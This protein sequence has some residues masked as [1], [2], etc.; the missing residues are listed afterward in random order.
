MIPPRFQRCKNVLEVLYHHAK[1]GGAQIP[2][3]LNFM[4]VCLSVTFWNVRVCVYD[5]SMK[6]LKY[7]NDFNTFG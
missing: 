1:F 3:T 5:L 6:A 7:K 2:K 4:F